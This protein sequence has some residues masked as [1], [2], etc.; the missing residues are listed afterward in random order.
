MGAM[1]DRSNFILSPAAQFR[2]DQM[3]RAK[4]T[5]E[6]GFFDQLTSTGSLITSL[7]ALGA[8]LAGED[9]AALALGAGTLAGAA[10]GSERNKQTRNKMIAGAEDQYADQLNIDAA[11]ARQLYQTP[12]FQRA[13]ATMHNNRSIMDMLGL[14]GAEI[15]FKGYQRSQEEAAK[16]S[17]QL[18][19]IDKHWEE[20]R[21]EGSREEQIAYLK[22]RD[23]VAGFSMPDSY[24]QRIANTGRLT[25]EDLEAR[26]LLS[27]PE[28]LAPYWEFTYQEGFDWNNPTHVAA[29]NR[30]LQPIGT[31]EQYELSMKINDRA[32]K[33][34]IYTTIYAT[35]AAEGV[36]F[37][38]AVL[39][40]PED[41]RA[42]AE[43]MGLGLV[44]DEFDRISNMLPLNQIT[45]ETTAY[46]GRVNEV[47]ATLTDPA[48][49]QPMELLDPGQAVANMIISTMNKMDYLNDAQA[50]EKARHITDILI[51]EQMRFYDIDPM[52]VPFESLPQ[53][54]QDRITFEVDILQAGWSAEYQAGGGGNYQ[55]FMYDRANAY[56][57][58]ADA[59]KGNIPDAEA[60]AEQ[61]GPNFTA[62]DVEKAQADAEAKDAAA[63]AGPS[64]EYRRTG[65]NAV[66][67]WLGDQAAAVVEGFKELDNDK[68]DLGLGDTPAARAFKKLQMRGVAAPEVKQPE[69][70]PA[71][72]AGPKPVFES[73]QIGK[74]D[75]EAIV[76]DQPRRKAAYDAA[77]AV[78]KTLLPD[79]T[80]DEVKTKANEIFIKN[81]GGLGNL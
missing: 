22:Y 74:L 47:L 58:R 25:K 29:A 14:S 62:E 53:E 3:D 30:L 39:L 67:R 42:R 48:T 78:A 2:K 34:E 43:T 37:D 69:A 68:Y 52:E 63:K 44:R 21:A 79:G 31:P 36:G 80:E 60:K 28:S 9:E 26:A 32:A 45:Q 54:Q 20:V 33:N 1:A 12:G 13:V 8:L 65:K 10:Q 19:E 23:Y 61:L 6:P 73:D 57:A 59:S 64:D 55:E 72:P 16:V 15:D 71:E 4:G 7:S 18:A 81:I 70:E 49:G 76:A 17:A 41:M 24:Y 75:I 38:K 35:M 5:K 56:A 11:G 66:Q 51:N 27:D 40:L 50:Q 46:V 77:V